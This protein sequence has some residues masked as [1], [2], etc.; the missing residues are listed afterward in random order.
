MNKYIIYNNKIKPMSSYNNVLSLE[1][2]KAYTLYELRNDVSKMNFDELTD[3][4]KLKVF[5]NVENDDSVFLC[6]MDFLDD[7]NLMID[8]QKKKIYDVSSNSKN[9]FVDNYFIHDDVVIRLYEDDIDYDERVKILNIDEEIVLN[10]YYNNANVKNTK[11]TLSVNGHC[12]LTFHDSVVFTDNEIVDYLNKE[13]YVLKI[14]NNNVLFTNGT[15]DVV[16]NTSFDTYVSEENIDCRYAEVFNNSYV[17]DSHYLF[18][19]KQAEKR[20]DVIMKD[21]I[22]LK[23]KQY[24]FFIGNNQ[25]K[26]VKLCKNMMTLDDIMARTNEEQFLKY[27]SHE[28][29][30]TSLL[31]TVNNYVPTKE[32]LKLLGIDKS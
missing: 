9:L 14:N 1:K 13:Y 5:H 16:S 23:N 3:K 7:F 17:F 31:E 27:L 22:M 20:I 10:K 21:C 26:K 11:T 28:G 2:Q 19:I 6:Y 29:Y 8:V 4:Y 32:E 12:G 15:T 24:A 30:D 25:I 18:K